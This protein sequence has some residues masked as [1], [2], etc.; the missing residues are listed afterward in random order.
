MHVCVLLRPSSPGIVTITHPNTLRRQAVHS[1]LVVCE[2]TQLHIQGIVVGTPGYLQQ[3]EHQQQHQQQCQHQH[4]HQG[5]SRERP[6]ALSLFPDL[7]HLHLNHIIFP[8][9][10]HTPA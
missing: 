6:L 5:M 10:A 8:V 7:H 3:K 1:C 4:Q 2:Q 9:R